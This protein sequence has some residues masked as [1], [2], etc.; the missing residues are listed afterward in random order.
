MYHADSGEQ[1]VLRYAVSAVG[2]ERREVYLRT[3]DGLPDGLASDVAGGLWV[4][5]YGTGEVRRYAPSGV[6]DAVV[7]VPAPQ[8]TSVA[9]GGPD[10]R[11][12]L[13][14]T[15]REGYDEARSRAEPMAGRLFRARVQHPGTPLFSA[16]MNRPAPAPGSAD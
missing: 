2:I 15:A 1:L 9:L 7:T 3:S 12:M 14:T 10:G 13:I 16:W 11:D 4:A 6:L 8:V 5:V